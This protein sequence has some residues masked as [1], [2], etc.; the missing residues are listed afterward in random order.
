[1]GTPDPV[2]FL[3]RRVH[4]RVVESYFVSEYQAHVTSFK[5]ELIGLF[6]NDPESRLFMSLLQAVA[7]PIRRMHDAGFW[8]N[9]LG[10]QNILLR[11]IKEQL[12]IYAHDD[13][14][15]LR[16]PKDSQHAF[17]ELSAMLYAAHMKKG[18][19]RKSG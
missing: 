10:N 16:L 3:E 19:C 1:M 18:D 5:T 9:D 2:A 12:R 15:G 17:S 6:R 8:H 14:Q 11:R 13:A 7:G 4:G